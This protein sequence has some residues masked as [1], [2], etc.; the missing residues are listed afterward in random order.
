MTGVRRLV[1]LFLEHFRKL[2]SCCLVLQGYLFAFADCFSESPTC[3]TSSI[4]H[5]FTRGEGRDAYSLG[6]WQGG[7]LKSC[8]PDGKGR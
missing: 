1:M 4:H 7:Q 8:L 2:S 6:L 3:L 5:P